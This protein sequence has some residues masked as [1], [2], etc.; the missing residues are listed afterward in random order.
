MSVNCTP[1]IA[2]YGI[3]GVYNAHPDPFMYLEREM[4]QEEE[5]RLADSVTRGDRLATFMAY[6]SS[7]ELGGSTVFPNLGVSIAP[8]KGSAAFW[9]NILSN[10]RTDQFTV[11]GGC[12]VLVGSKW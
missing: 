8:E 7:V 1:Q 5:S 6:L 3:G 2:N 11:H 9:W 10:A 12:P 4:A